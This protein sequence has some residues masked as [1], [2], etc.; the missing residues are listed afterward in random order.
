VED[1]GLRQDRVE[2][3]GTIS[4]KMEWKLLLRGPAILS[5]IAVPPINRGS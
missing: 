2:A 1:H 3:G 4:D 5:M